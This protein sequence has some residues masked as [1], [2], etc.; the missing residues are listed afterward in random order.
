MGKALA[1]PA[2]GVGGGGIDL[3]L[4]RPMQSVVLSLACLAAAAGAPKPA[5]APTASVFPYPM[6]VD[7]LD[8]GLTV[9]VVP[10][11]SA[12]L[13]SVRTAVRT[14]SRD[15]YERGHSG[16]AHFFEH[17]MFRGTE[18]Y[19]QKVYSE[20]VTRMGADTNA[21]TSSD[22]TVYQLDFAAEDLE[23][24]M[25]IESDRF[26][27]LAYAEDVFKTEAG[28]VYGEYRKNK[29]SPGY[30]LA[31][32]L[33][34][35]AFKRHTYRHLT[36]GF[37]DDIAAMPTMF[38][39][40]KGFFSRYY[41]PENVVLVVAGEV[42]PAAT[43][44][45][46]EKW[47][48]PWKPG[49]KPPKIKS[50]PAQKKERR[51]D[52]VYEGR[53]LPRIAVAYKGGAI[54]TDDRIWAA[55]LLLADLAFGRTSDIRKRLQLEERVVQSIWASPAMNRDPGL[56]EVSA[57][58]RD[59]AKIDYVL[60]QIDATVSRFR[61]TPPSADALADALARRKY[62]FLMNLDSPSSVAAQI[63][64]MAG[65]T[66][67]PR[68]HDELHTALE[69]VTPSDVQAAARKYLV[70]RQRTLAVMKGNK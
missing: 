21:Y 48:G 26:Q 61:E 4:C 8:N 17:M 32:A 11:P 51:I 66:G 38:T 41:R 42:D 70:A 52:V 46:A 35:A 50:E 34:A 37:E 62:S 65:I 13:V 28:A 45:F 54:D 23:R 12:G 68:F 56:W 57:S 58:V 29:A 3:V 36:I 27:N 20:I 7:E 33:H 44:A 25:D 19:P 43:L 9:V 6:H 55:S 59:P 47:W 14:G 30:V 53:T 40:S 15:E 63:A 10:M 22:L 31:E 1:P 16:F 67:S 2:N 39:Y 49:Y 64:R 18:K 69:R 60:E 5:P 24:V